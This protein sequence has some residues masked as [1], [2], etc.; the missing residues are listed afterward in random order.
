M[1]PWRYFMSL[2]HEK[3]KGNTQTH[4]SLWFYI[5]KQNKQ[6]LFYTYQNPILD[7]RISFGL[8]TSPPP[9]RSGYT[10]WI[11]KRGG[12]ESWKTKRIAPFFPANFFL[13]QFKKKIIK[14]FF[15]LDF[16]DFY[17]FWHFLKIYVFFLIHFFNIFLT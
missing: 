10:P 16:S 2:M 12:L 5:E 1:E 3:C 13:L 8:W 7:T 9:S 14:S 6:K 17:K 11:L 4:F 15:C